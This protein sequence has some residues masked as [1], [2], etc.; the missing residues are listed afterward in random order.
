MEIC[1]FSAAPADARQIVLER[2]DFVAKSGG[3][4]GAV[5]ELIDLLLTGAGLRKRLSRLT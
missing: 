2:V 5:R 3:G 1:G 4:K